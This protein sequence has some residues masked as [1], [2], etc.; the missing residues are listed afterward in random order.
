MRRQVIAAGVV[1][2]LAGGCAGEATEGS[3]GATP[4]GPTGSAAAPCAPESDLGMDT[5]GSFPYFA[6]VDELVLA[7]DVV[8]VGTVATVSCED[9]AG[10]MRDRRAVVDVEQ[11]LYGDEKAQVE[12]VS[13]GDEQGGPI[14]VDGVLPP[15]PGESAVWFL[16][17][18]TTVTGTY[19][20][21]GPQGRYRLEGQAL[22]PVT[23]D[24]HPR[25]DAVAEQ[26]ASL[27]RDGLTAAVAAAA[28]AIAAGEL[29]AVWANPSDS[30]VVRSVRSTRGPV[31]CGWQD[32]RFL[33]LDVTAF[34]PDDPRSRRTFV[35]NPT[36]SYG[37][38]GWAPDTD[39]PAD[40]IDTGWR[41]GTTQLWLAA[42]DGS[43]AA[44]LVDGPTVE[45]L[46][47]DDTGQ[48]CD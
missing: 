21:V 32:M 46:P 2:V 15:V 34:S 23:R 10:D 42:A 11:T 39:L 24:T 31:H 1:V 14:T 25:V 17:S 3:P 38:D 26:V 47:L 37:Q 27:G 35:A 16:Q 6:S 28:E 41:R 44:F 30:D 43:E 18:S 33:H 4:T 7:S 9:T 8:V 45:R 20:L 40:A 36:P 19:D 12:I 5:G 13:P 29:A 22:T 48:G